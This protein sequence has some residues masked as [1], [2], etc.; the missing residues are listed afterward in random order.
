MV[1]FGDKSTVISTVLL[2]LIVNAEVINVHATISRRRL[3]GSIKGSALKKNNRGRR[4]KMSTSFVE[5]SESQQLASLQR[6]WMI[7]REG[8]DHLL[9]I[10]KVLFAV[11]RMGFANRDPDQGHHGEEELK[12]L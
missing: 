9:G 7:M 1:R 2:L 10:A 6:E 12:E 5:M 11:Q 4:S 3:L 8:V